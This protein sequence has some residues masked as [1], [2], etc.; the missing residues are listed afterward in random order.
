MG[1]ARRGGCT[2][3]HRAAVKI[4]REAAKPMQGPAASPAEANGLGTVSPTTLRKAITSGGTGVGA[5]GWRR[6]EL[7]ALPPQAF[8]PLAAILDAIEEER[9]WPAQLLASCGVLLSKGK[10]QGVMDQ[11]V[12]RLLPRVVRAWSRTRSGERPP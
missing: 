10:G 9:A 7:R 12:I 8:P 3:D 11:R 1:P 5:D 4:A 6:D 2:A